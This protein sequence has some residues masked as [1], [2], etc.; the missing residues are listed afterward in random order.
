MQKLVV[1]I[2][3]TLNNNDTITFFVDEDDSNKLGIRFEN[4]ERNIISTKT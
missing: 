3:K 2:M 1:K 4:A